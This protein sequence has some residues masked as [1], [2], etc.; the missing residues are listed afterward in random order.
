[1]SAHTSI[2]SYNVSGVFVAKSC[3]ILGS[4][5]TVVCWAPLPMEFSRKEY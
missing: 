2:C 5:W 1:M 3:P 4:P